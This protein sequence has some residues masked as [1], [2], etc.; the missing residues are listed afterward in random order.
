M[1]VNYS[2]L[3][4]QFK[5]FKPYFYDL[6]K[7]VKSGEFTLGP[8]VEKFEKKFAKY[9]GVKYAVGT[10]TGT[11][12]LRL[13]LLSLGVGEGDEVI[14][15]ANTFVATVGAIVSTG[16]KP[17]L[18]DCDDRFQIDVKK[19]QKKISKKTKAIIPVHWAGAPCEIDKIL[20]IAKKNKIH[21]VEDACPAVGAYY[22]GKKCGTFGIVNAFSMHPLKPLNVWGDGGIIVTN[23]SKIYKFLK[24][25]RN[26]GL[27]DREHV[28][29]WGINNRLQPFQAVIGSR[30]LDR[31]ED[32]IKKRNIIAQLYDAEFSKINSIK[33]PNRLKKTR[34]VFQLYKI[35]VKN[36]NKLVKYLKKNKID[37]AIHYP[38]PIHLQKAAKNLGYKVGDFKITEAQSKD[39][40]TLPC[41]QFLKKNQAKFVISTIK[42]FY[43]KKN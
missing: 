3:N 26:H 31:M 41:H 33:V 22:K 24:L 42:K 2:Y 30:S 8:F 43:E 20:K 35:R 39:I 23:N 11:D 7:L 9:I 16:A 28:S 36:R 19:I 1:K 14:T 32:Y 40:I 12:A 18:V 21:I 27:K 17:I 34:E 25:Y 4:Q 38:I 37:C 15:V 13:S 10:N 29:I 6:E 5:N